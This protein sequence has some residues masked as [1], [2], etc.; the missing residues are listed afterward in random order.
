MVLSGSSNPPFPPPPPSV[1]KAVGSV[2]AVAFCVTTY[3][4]SL[5]SFLP[6]SAP[7]QLCGSLLYFLWNLLLLAPRLLALAL[8]ASMFPCF[9]FTH[10]LCS[11]LLL[12]FCAWRSNTD[13]M[14]G[15]AVGEWLF[16]G[17]VALIW[18]FSWFCVAPGATRQRATLYHGYALLDVC[19][20]CAL[21]SWKA[22]VPP[23][24]AAATSVAV[25]AV[26]V[27]GLVL[28]VVYYRFFHPNLR[29]EEL[30]GV[31]AQ[32][33][34][35]SDEPDGALRSTLSGEMDGELQF[36]SMAA[37]P[38]HDRAP[39]TNHRMKKLAENFYL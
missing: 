30:R 6:S 12:L 18:Y 33:L 3:H 19:L 35:E 8:F 37:V 7:P 27:L 15:D 24:H 32:T 31:G 34:R 21:W 20:L 13:F 5:R 1:L 9:I 4:R 38:E 11:W 14:D 23:P 29:K 10:F 16:R 17:T 39:P 2:S 26:Y 28:K 36:R 22:P 25:V